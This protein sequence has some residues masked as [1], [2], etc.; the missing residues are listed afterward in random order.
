MI[1]PKNYNI[2]GE[3]YWDVT[4]GD[5]KN[6]AI[7]EYTRTKKKEEKCFKKYHSKDGSI[8]LELE[9]DKPEIGLSYGLKW[10]PPTKEE[11][12]KLLKESEA[13]QTKT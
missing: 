11:Y 8:I 10:I 12:E 6:K 4:I 13:K 5:S 3:E 1:L 9:V 7:G 2:S